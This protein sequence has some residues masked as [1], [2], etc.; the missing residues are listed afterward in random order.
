MR[1]ELEER[2]LDPFKRLLDR[3]RDYLDARYRSERTVKNYMRLMRRYVEHANELEPFERRHVDSFLA[4]L[5]REGSSGVNQRWVYY[6]I[7]TFFRAMERPWPFEKSEVPKAEENEEAPVLQEE[8]MAAMEG[9][10]RE[11]RN[12]DPRLGF[13]Y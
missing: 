7:R 12:I 11:K 5:K 8:D 10:A 6:V 9:V 2:P 3:F 13:K 1:E 4:R